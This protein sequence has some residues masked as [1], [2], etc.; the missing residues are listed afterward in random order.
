MEV[1]RDVWA[2]YRHHAAQQTARRDHAERARE[3]RRHWA[4][5]GREF[6][7]ASRN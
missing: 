2:Y 7:I 6:R 4:A 1:T 5:R 3:L